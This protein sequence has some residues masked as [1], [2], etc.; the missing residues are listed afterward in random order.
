M[1]NGRRE[2]AQ[3]LLVEAIDA[4]YAIGFVQAL[5]KSTANPAKGARE[6]LKAFGKK[7]S[8]LWFEHATVHDLTDVKVYQ[9]VLDKLAV[10]FRHALPNYI[11]GSGPTKRIGAFLAYEKPAQS[12]LAVLS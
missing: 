7:A 8:K 5:I 6:V 12:V 10:T 1:S 9:F 3:A 4:S 11:A 2:F